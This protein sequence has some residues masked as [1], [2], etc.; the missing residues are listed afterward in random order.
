MKRM[1]YVGIPLGGGP[2]GG[3]VDGVRGGEEG[4]VRKRGAPLWLG[5]LK[6]WSGRVR[7]KTKVPLSLRIIYKVYIKAIYYLRIR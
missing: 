4:E 1:E 2:G 6:T 3:P 7:V 5:E